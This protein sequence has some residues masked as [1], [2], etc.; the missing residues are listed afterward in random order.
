MS[1]VAEN[2]GGYPLDEIQLKKIKKSRKD[3][4]S[5]KTWIF[6]GLYERCGGEEG[7]V[8]G[9]GRGKGRCVGKAEK[10]PHFR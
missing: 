6:P 5:H 4:H 1:S 10:E 7:S 9:A 3:V 2:Q 8:G